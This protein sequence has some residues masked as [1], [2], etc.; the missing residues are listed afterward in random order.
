[1]LERSEAYAQAIEAGRRLIRPEALIDI[2]DPD[3]VIVGAID[4]GHIP[5]S[6]PDQLGNK[7]FKTELGRRV[8]LE[9]NRWILNGSGQLY[10]DDP[11]RLDGESGYISEQ[12]SCPYCTY[13]AESV[14][15]QLCME[16]MATLQACSVHFYADDVDGVPADFRID[17]YSGSVLVWSRTVTDNRDASVYFEGFTV[18]AVT[19]IRVT[20][21]ASSIPNRR[22]RALEIVPGIYEVWGGK[23]LKSVDIVH[24]AAFDC[25]SVPYGS[26]DLDVYSKDRRF[27]PSNRTGLFLSLASRQAVP[28][29]FRLRL[30]DGSWEKIPVG[31][32]FRKDTGWATNADDML[33]VRWSL[34]DIIGLLSNRTFKAPAVLP[35]VIED[36]LAAIVGLLGRNFAKRWQ[37]DEEL[38]GTPVTCSRDQVDG[39]QVNRLLQ[40]I[41]MAVGGY[42]KSDPTTG[43][44]HLAALSDEPAGRIGLLNMTAYP[45]L[46][47]NDDVAELTFTVNGA[48]YVVTGTD[49]AS[50]NSNSIANPFLKDRAAVDRAARMILTKYGGHKIT[51]QGRGDMTRELGDVMAIETPFGATMAGR[52]YRQELRLSDGVMSNVPALFLLANGVQ[53]YQNC[54]VVTQTGPVSI[55][56]GVT[57]VFAVLV[58]GGDGGQPGKDGTWYA[59]GA[60]GEGGQGGQVFSSSLP[61]NPGQI[62]D[63]IIGAGGAPGQPGQPTTVS[64]LTSAAGKRVNGWADILGGG[65]YAQNGSSAGRNG[66]NGV[67]GSQGTPNTGNGGQG[68]GGGAVGVSGVDEEGEYYVKYY[69]G[70]G[71]QGGTGGSGVLLLYYDIPDQVSDSDTTQGG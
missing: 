28:L 53:M 4:T 31:V 52:L 64:V 50:S 23:E 45:Q 15:V 13:P 3:L 54:I 67:R 25:M 47:A 18:Y 34:T 16:N 38:A 59:N 10:P 51:V 17:I 33:T 7:V 1:M 70:S 36:W 37:I 19:A 27:D 11:G 71:G 41:G 56:E 62:F 42:F 61:C 8:T 24:Q 46:A 30:E 14:W 21:L 32:F 65:V 63:V 9:R 55:P 20:F 69:P 2:S 66:R 6:V 49:S 48:T 43:N 44:L 22:V 60:A 5:Y 57:E 35:T 58:G 26:A 29:W 40:F 68:G 39:M 12:L